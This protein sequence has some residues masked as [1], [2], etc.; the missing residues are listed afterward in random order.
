[1]SGHNEAKTFAVWS[2]MGKC[3]VRLYIVFEAFLSLQVS[4]EH[5]VEFLTSAQPTMAQCPVDVDVFTCEGNERKRMKKAVERTAELTRDVLERL[6]G[7]VRDSICDFL[8]I[9]FCRIA[10]PRP[11][12][13]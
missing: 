13:Q 3:K 4:P 10:L 12:C 5:Y 8:G 6:K 9:I 2:Y 1:M 7:T 11:W